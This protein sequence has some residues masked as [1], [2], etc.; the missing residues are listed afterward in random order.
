MLQLKG[1]PTHSN[2]GRWIYQINEE[3][4]IEVQHELQ[5]HLGINSSSEELTSFF[6]AE[7]LVY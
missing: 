1:T 7:Y 6:H 2:N 4:K 3:S 5:K